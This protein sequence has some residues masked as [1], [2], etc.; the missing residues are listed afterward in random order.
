MFN[1][2]LIFIKYYVLSVFLLCFT[3]GCGDAGFF[4]KKAGICFLKASV[5]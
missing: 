1:C 3:A 4:T 5:T 2:R